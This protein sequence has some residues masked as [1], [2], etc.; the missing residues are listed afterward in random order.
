MSL[1]DP[2]PADSDCEWV[3]LWTVWGA[4]GMTIGGGMVVVA[5]LIG[6]TRLVA[7]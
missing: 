1:F 6:L 3:P 5:I 2:P 4:L 7:Q